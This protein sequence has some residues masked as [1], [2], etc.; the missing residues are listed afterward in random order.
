[1]RA[2]LRAL[3]KFLTWLSAHHTTLD[4]ARQTH[5]DEFLATYP[6]GTRHLPQFLGWAHATGRS[7]PL[8]SPTYRSQQPT[9]QTVSSKHW[10]TVERLL[11]DESIRVDTRIC[12]LFVLLYG[13]RPS[14]ISR[15]TRDLV[16]VADGHV[17]VRFAADPIVLPPGV[18]DLLRQH[19]H[20]LDNDREQRHSPWL[21]PGRNP[22]R[23]IVHGGLGVRLKD[24]GISPQAGRTTAIMQLAA[25]LPAA[26]L[27]GF[28]GIHP[29]TAVTWSKIAAGDWNSYPAL[30]RSQSAQLGETDTL[31]T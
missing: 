23:P 18:D 15:M 31:D 28:L 13:Q 7:G 1:M 12:G 10:D 24:L 2:H 30:R 29:Q 3:G 19:V 26:V 20:L 4:T 6:A 5:I 11:H 14:R 9:P 27:A 17:L 8:T 16:T 25:E 21:F 22:A